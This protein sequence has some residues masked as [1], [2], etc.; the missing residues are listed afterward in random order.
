MVRIGAL[1][2]EIIDCLLAV[3]GD[4]QWF[5]YSSLLERVLHNRVFIAPLLPNVCGRIALPAIAAL[6]GNRFHTHPS[7][8]SISRLLHNREAYTCAFVLFVALDA[9]EDAEDALRRFTF[10]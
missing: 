8:H 5:S 3:S 2:L 7:S 6:A 9:L 4:F 10:T 1:A